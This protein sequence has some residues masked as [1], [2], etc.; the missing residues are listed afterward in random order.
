[1]FLYGVI[2]DKVLKLKRN[3]DFSVFILI[4]NIRTKA[5]SLSKKAN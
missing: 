3:Y 2:Q 1:M 5:R 4:L